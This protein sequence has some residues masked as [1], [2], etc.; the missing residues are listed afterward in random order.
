MKVDEIVFKNP[1]KSDAPKMFSCLGLIPEL[2]K[3]SI[4]MY[5]LFCDIFKETSMIAME[6]EQVVGAAIGFLMPSDPKNY[7]MWQLGV[8][9]QWRQKGLATDLVRALLKSPGLSAIDWLSCTVEADNIAIMTTFRRLAESLDTHIELADKF[10][11]K[12]FLPYIHATER[13]LRM[14]PLSLG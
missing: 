14:G 11:S 10:D 7:F 8:L 2:E 4:Y 1:I 5:M 6:G 13:E 12:D 9:P 3:N